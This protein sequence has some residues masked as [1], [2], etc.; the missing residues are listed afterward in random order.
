MNYLRPSKLWPVVFPEWVW[1]GKPSSPSG[2]Y[3][4]F[5]DG[6]EAGV[7]DEILKILAASNVTAVFF[8]TG[9][10]V[11]K[12][13]PLAR[14]V[15]QAGHEIGSHSY[16]HPDAWKTMPWKWNEDVRKGHEIVGEILGE[17]PRWFRP[18]YGH[19]IPGFNKQPDSTRLVMWTFMPGD[20][21]PN[22][23]SEE[24]VN[25][26]RKYLQ[27][28][29]VMVLHDSLKS[30]DRILNSLPALIECVHATNWNILPLSGMVHKP[31]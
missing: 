13:K 6:P 3:L 29:D 19:F 14:E 2:V 27:A 25:R 7:T 16:S 5:D 21:D 4:T 23:Q 28:G 22:V 1:G 26:V 8:M 15:Y 9:K 11:E 12:N 20:F 18:P 30:K 31:D 24:I 17:T 10:A